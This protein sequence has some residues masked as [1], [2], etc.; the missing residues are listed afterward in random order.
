VRTRVRINPLTIINMKLIRLA[1]LA[2][3]L[4]LTAT[5]LAQGYRPASQTPLYLDENAPIEQRVQDALSLMTLAEKCRLAYAQS[6]FSSPG[7]PRLGIPDLWYSDGPHGVRAEINWN[8]WGY[9]EWT[10]DSITAFP[11]LTCL[12]ATW[13]PE[14][15]RQYGVAVGEEARFRK[16]NVLLGPGVNIYRTPLNGRNFEYMGEDPYLASRMVVPYIQG[17]QQNGVGACVK[18]YVLNDQEEF[19]GHVDV[20]V[21]ERALN[22]IYLPPFKAAVKEG[23][24]WSLM[25]SYNQYLDQHVSH[26][27]VLLDEILKQGWGFDGVV[28]S[29]W[30]AVHDTHE[31]AFNGLDSEMG[32]YTNG[33]TSESGFSYDNYYLGTAYLQMCQRGEV[34]DSVIN[35]KAARILRL[36][37]RTEKSQNARYPKGRIGSQEQLDA[38]RTIAQEGIV[39]LKNASVEGRTQNFKPQ[40][41]LPIRPNRYQR[42]LVVGENA[43]RSLCMGGGSSELKTKTEISPLE[44]L[45]QRFGGQ[46]QIDYAQ[47]YKSGGSFYGRIEPISAEVSAQLRQEAVDKAR[48]ADLVIYVGGLNKNHFSDC[49]GGDRLTYDLDYGQNEL[50]NAL[51]DVNPRMV[52][53]IVSG[54]AF[55]MPW[56]SRVPALVQSWYLGSMAG[57]ALA[58]ILS[59]DVCPSGKTIFSYPASLAYS[60]AHQLGRVSYPG[61]SPSQLPAAYNYGKKNPTSAKLLSTA[62]KGVDNLSSIGKN[63]SSSLQ[64]RNTSSDPATHAGNGDEA[65]VYAEDIL[66]GYRWFDYFG[67]NGVQSRQ[68]IFPFGY[69]LSYTTFDYGDVTV[70]GSTVAVSVTNTGS[71]EGKETVQFYVGDEKASVIRPKK[72]LKYFEKISLKPGET[73]TV[74]Y[75]MSDDDFKFYDEK[76]HRW[77]FEPGKFTIY[78]CSSSADVREK[79]TIS[80]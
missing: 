72:E 60:P 51:L 24:V 76:Q 52:C 33:L 45:Q 29:D 64:T 78:I 73:R 70:Y 3:S 6:K 23:K 37:F 20:K 61:V 58:D 34:P 35:D 18:H 12:A 49:E 47:G 54:N 21:S 36:L 17:V 2:A 44:G 77:V 69:G 1:A 10:C 26:N 13:N 32:S 71:V 59:G 11:A 55:R 14:L 9:A 30:G 74:T 8:N 67:E 57:V 48:Q 50:I 22:E 15:A 25:G 66:V 79:E 16:K 53:V 62:T 68:V 42:I 63:F 75:T 41:L 43:T 4:T 38:A 7:V 40:P 80:R 27:E 46:F 56:L 28:V 39:L 31:A 19:R 65:V 5:A